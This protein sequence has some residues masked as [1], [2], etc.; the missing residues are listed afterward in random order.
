M[1]LM[2]INSGNTKDSPEI[3]QRKRFIFP[4]PILSEAEGSIARPYIAEPRLKNTR[5]YFSPKQSGSGMINATNTRPVTAWSN[6]QL[7]TND[8]T[9]TTPNFP[10]NTYGG[11]YDCDTGILTSIYTIHNVTESDYISTYNNYSNGS[12]TFWVY[13][14]DI[15]TYNTD[16]IAPI[17]DKFNWEGISAS[18]H[19]WGFTTLSGYPNSFYV[20]LPTSVLPA[21]SLDGAKQWVA[22]NHFQVIGQRKSGP[23]QIDIGPTIIKPSRGKQL[24]TSSFQKSINFSFN[25][26]TQP[27]I[28]EYE[29]VDYLTT[30]GYQTIINTGVNGNTTDLK[31]YGDAD[32]IKF[33]Q[34]YSLFGNSINDSYRNWGFLQSSSTSAT[35]LLFRV[36]DGNATVGVSYDPIPWDS[37]FNFKFNLSQD[38]IQ[39]WMNGQ[40]KISIATD[41]EKTAN[42]VAICIGSTRYN[43]TN[44]DLDNVYR[45]RSFK[46]W[47]GDTILRDYKPCVRLSDNKPG[48]YDLVNQTFNPSIGAKDFV[49]G[50]D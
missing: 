36:Y 18:L 14:G 17:S 25:Y 32:L 27:I 13:L 20:M 3:M 6:I 49:P 31:I 34:Y 40:E 23:I 4:Q 35:W 48:F 37:G 21:D 50:Y 2:T 11:Y 5:I 30:V 9:I 39:C 1:A 19:N 26:W 16:G 47:S 33:K 28:K 41:V 42:T 38:Y 10:T 44:T 29:F 7:T 22:N 8:G 12:S 15:N 45:I 43:Y 46:F 24:I